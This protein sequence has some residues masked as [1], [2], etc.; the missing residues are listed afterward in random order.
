MTIFSG[1]AKALSRT[2]ESFKSAMTLFSKQYPDPASLEELEEILLSADLGYNTVESILNIV[3]KSR[4]DIK[5]TIRSH[6]ISLLPDPRP[7]ESL[8]IPHVL[9][10]VGVNGTGKTTSA[11]KLAH[12]YKNQGNSVV[13]VA[14]DTYRDAAVEQLKIWSDRIGVRLVCNDRSREPSSVLYDGLKAARSERSDITIVDTAGRLHTYRNLMQELT[15]MMNVREKH[16]PELNASSLITIDAS[17]GQNSLIQ[18]RE[19]SSSVD[20]KGA[21]LTKLDGTAKGGIIFSLYQDLNL[22]VWYVGTGEN[23]E[24]L[25]PFKS[26]EFVNYLLG[27]ENNET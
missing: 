9:F 18:A 12:Y 15:K 16:F 6:L 26:G 21:I 13:L 1:V 27:S 7:E 14:A 19:F 22:P 23:L 5:N 4:S 20:L 2:R 8:T 10:I 25:Y 3:S 11:A 24:D 17:L